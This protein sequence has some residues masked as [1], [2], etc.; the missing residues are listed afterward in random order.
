MEDSRRQ[1][2]WD[3]LTETHAK[4][5]HELVRTL[6]ERDVLKAQT[7][8]CD[9]LTRRVEELESQVDRGNG[10]YDELERTH[11]ELRRDDSRRQRELDALSDKHRTLGQELDSTL[12]ALTRKCQPLE[13]PQ[14]EQLGVLNRTVETL[15]SQVSECNARY[16]QL[17]GQ[18]A[19][20]VQT[21][22]DMEMQMDI[23]EGQLVQCEAKLH[24]AG[25]KTRECEDRLSACEKRNA[26]TMEPKSPASTPVDDNDA[27]DFDDADKQAIAE[28]SDDDQTRCR[29][30]RAIGSYALNKMA[31][32]YDDTFCDCY[33]NH[34]VRCP[35]GS[36]YPGRC[37]SLDDDGL[38]ACT[39]PAGLSYYDGYTFRKARKTWS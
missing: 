39:Q 7:T 31:D 21:I 19:K 32:N 29:Q 30:S 13:E 17:V 34:K 8:R 16:K 14:T 1:L 6:A 24:D 22:G 27:R 37:T 5:E 20:C 38:V 10:R 33:A 9:A 12:M 3:A 15:V 18:H 11:A 36:K 2:E 26:V 23:C 28:M 25:R 35:K 4:L